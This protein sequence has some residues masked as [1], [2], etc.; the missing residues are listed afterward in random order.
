MELK[1]I[2]A[3]I[4]ILVVIYIYYTKQT[5]KNTTAKPATNGN[6]KTPITAGDEKRALEIMEKIDNRMSYDL[7]FDE[8]KKL[9]GGDK[10]QY[11]DLYEKYEEKGSATLDDYKQIF[12]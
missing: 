3:V 1:Y 5:K 4:L 8:F 12:G 2:I 9:T 6:D 7:S 10:T 11:M